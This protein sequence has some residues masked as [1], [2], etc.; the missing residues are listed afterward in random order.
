MELPANPRRKGGHMK[1]QALT[2]LNVL[3]MLTAL[4]V[5]AQS[6]ER[7]VINIPFNFIVGQKTLLAGDYTVGNTEGTA[8][9]FG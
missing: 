5:S 7:A 9:R 4:S 8:T 1:R 2:L 6:Q 3:L